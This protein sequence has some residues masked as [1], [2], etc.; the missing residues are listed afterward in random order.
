ML[1]E[2]KTDVYHFNIHITR[3]VNK[4]AKKLTC[5]LR[6]QHTLCECERN[7]PLRKTFICEYPKI[8]TMKKSCLSLSAISRITGSRKIIHT[9][10]WFLKISGVIPKTLTKKGKKLEIKIKCL[11]PKFLH[12]SLVS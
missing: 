1:M 12:I 10:G 7:M 5:T 2:A 3:N 4:S 8:T 6:I 9:D 11:I